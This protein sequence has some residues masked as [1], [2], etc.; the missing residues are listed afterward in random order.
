MRLSG[1]FFLVVFAAIAGFSCRQKTRGPI[2]A[3]VGEHVL[4][5]D[6]LY[7]SIPPEYSDF[8]TREQ[9][10][11]YVKQWIDNEILYEEALRQ[12]IDKEDA[13]KARLARMKQDLLC[14]EMVNRNSISP[15][16]IQI[17]DD[18]IQNYYNENKT[19]FLREKDAA[20]Y[21]QI[22]VEEAASAW[23]V[24]NQATSDNFLLLASK[25]S[26]VPVA[27]PRTTPFV[28]VGDIP[29]QIA[30]EIA[31]VRIKGVSSPVK[32]DLGYLIVLVLDKQPKGSI[33]G[34]EEVR[35]DI[36]NVLST[37]TQN[38]AIEQMLSGLRSKMEVEVHLDIVPN[39]QK[40]P[41]DSVTAEKP[42]IDSAVKS[43]GEKN[44]D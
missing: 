33:R 19:K 13:I 12:K 15:Q 16:N 9:M 4:T 37:K 17:S 30:R 23:S 35:D 27:D 39:N 34:I 28:N 22:V 42:A 25:Y 44:V 5:L 26:K 7:K 43:N 1:V 2:V 11:N 31:T 3:R 10:I 36:V 20:R 21:I 32:T 14:A 6:D 41:S 8:I 29:P 24:K 38:V 40:N 18:M